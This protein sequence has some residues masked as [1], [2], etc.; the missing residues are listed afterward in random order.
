MNRFRK[1]GGRLR[2]T[3]VVPLLSGM[4]LTAI[5]AGPSAAEQSADAAPATTGG[6]GEDATESSVFFLDQFGPVDS[7]DAAE[8]AFQK[9][10]AGILAA[11]GGVLVVPAKTIATW[12]PSN[13]G[14]EV[15]RTPPPPEQTRR[16][17][18]GSGVT[19]IDARGG[20]ARILPPQVTGLE[21]GRVLDLPPGNSLPFWGMYPL[22]KV[23][24]GI[25]RGS[26]SYR[27]WLQED[28]PAGKDSRFY[29]KTIRGVFPGMF[30]S[31]GEYGVVERLCVKS[32]G[33]DPEKKLWFFTADTE[34]GHAK[35]TIMGNKNHVNVMGIDTYSHNENQTC[36][37]LLQ[38]HNYSQGDNY[39]YY[40]RMLYMGDN[41]STAGDENAILYG[42]FI[43]SEAGSFI[44][45]VAAWDP[46]EG[47]LTFT[48]GKNEHT[49]GTGRPIIS[50]NPAKWITKGTVS[51]VRPASW[52]DDSSSMDNPVF[53]GKQ[54]PTTIAPN[55]LEV[56]SLRVG[57]L[58]RL[59]A[60]APVTEE[61][62]GR[63]FAVDEKDECVPGTGGRAVRRWYLIDSV[64]PNADGTKDI[65]II[66]HWWGAKSA[67]SPVLYKPDN[68]SADGREK[69]LR[70]VIAPGANAY[71]VSEAVNSVP[72]NIRNPRRIIRLA[73]TPFTG[74]AADYAAGDPV[75]Q[76]VGPDP[77]KPTTLRAW[78]WDNVPTAL[79]S[80]VL[81][82]ANLGQT[83][84][85]TVLMVHGGGGDAR[86]DRESRYDR[87]PVFDRIVDIRASCNTAIRFEGD[88]ADAA[89]LFKQ[90]HDRAQPIKWL[91]GDGDG[92]RAKVAAL[93]VA[94]DSGDLD[95]VGGDARFSGSLLA[96][97]LSGGGL[98]ARN[99]RGKNVAVKAGKT[100]VPIE[101]PVEET[102]GDYAVF[103]EQNWIGNRA[104]VNKGP[105]GFTVKF[106]KPTPPD[107]SI[108]WMIVR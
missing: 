108:D 5:N 92:G 106:D 68:Y 25:L 77:F 57:G 54:Y 91:Y 83:M 107:A 102:D 66:R 18:A 14:Q 44:G 29:V 4:L 90:P 86:S 76:A 47:S 100:D 42:G 23:H 104:I 24:N 62:V 96:G 26:T 74:T 50:L 35:G 98:P 70:Y 28:A 30:M 88:T 1:T 27:E 95:F 69:P 46:Q 33:Y 31:C 38:R 94:P 36:D 40:A 19:V 65:R 87:N 7:V 43:N 85:D 99:L 55:H 49:L 73:P 51:I 75:E 84:R 53:Q 15:W 63:Y 61:A 103:V 17:G 56:R 41:H 52:I 22:L 11:G 72:A 16:W 2:A 58:I 6:Q 21:L 64:T 93:T 71:D 3:V 60:D 8:A 81:D 9:A 34:A 80:A 48:E 13:S 82:V 89:I 12:K 37:M 101:F 39:M 79:P 45:K 10:S 32:L 105:R 20:T 78:M 59:S 97:G 67:G